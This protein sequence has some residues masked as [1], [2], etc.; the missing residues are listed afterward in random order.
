ME[1]TIRVT[2]RGR[3][4]V[5]P[6]TIRLFINIEGMQEEYDMAVAQ[7]AAMTEEVKELFVKLD[8]GRDEVKTLSF[9]V[10]TQYESYQAEDRSW[11]KRLEGYKFTHRMKVEFAVDNKRLGRALYA[12][13]HAVAHPEFHI[14]YTVAEPENCKN[15]LLAAAIK[16][17]K[18]K[19]EVLTKAAGVILGNIV[20]IDYS[21]A[22]L[23]LVSR[24]MEQ[25]MLADTCVR[26]SED[27]GNAYNIDV[28]PDNIEV[29]DNV[30]VMWEIK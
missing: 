27:E 11:K 24:P 6:D 17:S 30:T 3:L 15:E 12:L 9:N 23:E 18:A 26:C 29:T 13:G 25:F 8:F 1:R 2:G 5:K 10:T 28:N 21:W 7:S 4:S 16:D 20:T 22:E 14:E 19:A